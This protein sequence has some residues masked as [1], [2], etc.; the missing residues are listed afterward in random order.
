MD[1]S[2]DLSQATES[3]TSSGTQNAILFGGLTM[4]LNIMGWMRGQLHIFTTVGSWSICP[5]HKW[6]LCVVGIYD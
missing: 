4:L 2:T 1:N 6:I 5:G 3:W